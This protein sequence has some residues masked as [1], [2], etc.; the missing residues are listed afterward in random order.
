MSATEKAQL[1]TLA[2][3]VVL[4][5]FGASV[6]N[7]FVWDDHLV[8][9]KNE[10]VQNPSNLP[11]LFTRSYLT[12]P[13]AFSEL[14]RKDIGSGEVTY[15][16]VTT[17]SYFI[18]FS[19]FGYEAGGYHLASLL[20]HSLNAFLLMLFG[21]RLG[22]GRAGAVFA[23]VLF[24]GHAAAAESVHCISYNENLLCLA[25]LLGG[26]LLYSSADVGKKRFQI[27]ALFFLAA[28]SK[29]TGLV[30]LPLLYL[31]DRFFRAQDPPRKMRRDILIAAAFYIAVRFIWMR[32]PEGWMA[33]EG[34][35]VWTL[36]KT[37]ALA[38]VWSLFPNFVKL[39]LP[40]DPELMAGGM[41]AAALFSAALLS[42]LIWTAWRWQKKRPEA[43]FGLFFWLIALV[44]VA[45]LLM[46]NISGRYLYIPLAGFCLLAGTVL[47]AAVSAL[48]KRWKRGV[49]ALALVPAALI[50]P[51]FGSEKP[52]LDD[53]SFFRE[54]VKENPRIALGHSEFARRLRRQGALEEAIRHYR[55][56]LALDPA[57]A[58]DRLSLGEI[59]L[60]TGRLEEAEL[61]LKKAL[62]LRPGWDMASAA[63]DILEGVRSGRLKLGLK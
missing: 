46:S 32:I 7:G 8:I 43:S 24:A 34:A 31:Y 60:L 19:F 22:L 4:V 61:E 44:P 45:P 12:D 48:S 57:W 23:G 3:A 5:V 40:Q 63:L 36:F 35:N 39:T 54:I 38:W 59:Y 52:W 16:P 26:L 62:E 27:L 2:A 49:W 17:L 33:V 14:G 56:A 9:T 20:L 11:R 29:E 55:Q 10:F 42:F 28:F 21:L 53:V 18:L 37:G 6:F 1:F 51:S 13:A 58:E 50:L 30:F 47:A 25:F 15:R 41:N